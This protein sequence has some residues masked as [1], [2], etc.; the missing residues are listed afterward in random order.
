MLGS[1]Y[2]FGKEINDF[3]SKRRKEHPEEEKKLRLEENLYSIGGKLIPNVVSLVG[4]CLA[5]V[6]KDYTTGAFITGVSEAVRFF[7]HENF[8]E[9]KSDY[10]YKDCLEAIKKV[11]KKL[12]DEKFAD[13]LADLPKKKIN[14]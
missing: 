14:N 8:L 11:N 4:I 6:K 3:Y 5:F 7:I 13:K 10:I 9:R 2:F 1:D 12:E